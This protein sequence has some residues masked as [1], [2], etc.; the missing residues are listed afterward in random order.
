MKKYC[1]LDKAKENILKGPR[2]LPINWGNVANIRALSDVQLNDLNWI[3]VV[4]PELVFD[5]ATQNRLPDM[6]IING[7][8]VDVT[9]IIEDKTQEELDADTVSI[10][11]TIST[12][13]VQQRRDAHIAISDQLDMIY[14][15]EINNTTLW[16]DYVT[17]IKEQYPKPE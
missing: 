11:L 14:W 7:D 8:H 17:A 6:L 4:Y 13:Y 10:A 16:K 3:P 9:F 15:D 1:L 2:D 12:E 5:S